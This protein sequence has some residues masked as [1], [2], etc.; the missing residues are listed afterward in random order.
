MKK[1]L[2]ISIMLCSLFY[3][4]AD[5]EKENAV[6]YNDAVIKE[7]DKA[8]SIIQVL[9]AF[10]IFDRFPEEQ[11]KLLLEFNISK[12]NLVNIAPMKEDDSLRLGAIEL[13]DSYTNILNAEYQNIYDI[14]HDSVYTASD[15]VTVDSLMFAMYNKWEIESGKIA[16]QQ[17][18]FADRYDIMLDDKRESAK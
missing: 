1:I 12:N 9:F 4:C 7:V 14:M 13:V 10:E 11:Q 3:A 8:D 15:S 16:V 17:K 18:R 6:K 2:L 5:K